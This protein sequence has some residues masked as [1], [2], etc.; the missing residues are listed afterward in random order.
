MTSPFDPDELV[1]LAEEVGWRFHDEDELLKRIHEWTNA[2]SNT[3]SAKVLYVDNGG[4]S[5][6]EEG[7][8]WRAAVNGAGDRP[9]FVYR[10]VPT[11][12]ERYYLNSAGDPV[13]FASEKA[14]RQ[15][16][17]RLNEELGINDGL[18]QA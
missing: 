10:D 13:R 14:A 6:P 7:P 16:A 3:P 1:R 12:E 9:W 8:A 11:V 15:V 5:Y 4:G 18:G 17:D 2:P